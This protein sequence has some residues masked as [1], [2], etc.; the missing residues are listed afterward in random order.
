MLQPDV[1]EAFRFAG[2]PPHHLSLAKSDDRIHL[3]DHDQVVSRISMPQTQTSW[4]ALYRAMQD[5]LPPGTLHRGERLVSFKQSGHKVTALFASGRI[6]QCDVL[7]GADGATSSVRTQ[8]LPRSRPAYAGYVARRGLVPDPM[9]GA[10]ARAKIADPMA[11]QQGREHLFL[12]Y[13]IPGEGGPSDAR[14]RRWNW[15]WFRKVPQGP[16]LSRLLTDRHGA[17]HAFSLP[18]GGVAQAPSCRRCGAA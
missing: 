8:L 3:N 9:L 11:F 16:A 12:V 18:P 10:D 1:L 2:I 4:N 13:R 6:E 15:V 7:I 5:A 17:T 14:R